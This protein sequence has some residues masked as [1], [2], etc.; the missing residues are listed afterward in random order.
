MSIS[1]NRGRPRHDTKAVVCNLADMIA[2]RAP[3][4]V[5]PDIGFIDI[6]GL[7]ALYDVPHW[8]IQALVRD[9]MFPAPQFIGK[10]N[11]WNT[12]ALKKWAKGHA[13]AR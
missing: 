9:G 10:S 13:S 8:R 2:G 1:N 11:L 12:A 7:M 6:K 5:K 3:L 4:P